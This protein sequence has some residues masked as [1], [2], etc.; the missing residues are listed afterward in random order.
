MAETKES[1]YAHTFVFCRQG[2]FEEGTSGIDDVVDN[3]S[4][5]FRVRYALDDIA[6]PVF[7]SGFPEYHGVRPISPIQPFRKEEADERD[8]RHFYDRDLKRP[9]GLVRVP[10]FPRDVP[11]DFGI[12]KSFPKI[13]KP[14]GTRRFR[15]FGTPFR[16]NGRFISPNEGNGSCRTE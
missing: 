5:Q 15:Y 8:A 7:F 1:E 3:D 14:I 16:I 11:C 4:R 10:E 13:E 6:K 9:M 2:G 12:E